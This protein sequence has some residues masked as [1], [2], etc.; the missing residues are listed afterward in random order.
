MARKQLITV[1][2]LD[3]DRLTALSAEISGGRVALRSWLTAVAPEQIPQDKP[4][5]LGPWIEQQLDAAGIARG[6]L[7]LSMGRSDVVLK[8]LG[9]PAGTGGLASDELSGMVRLQM[10]RQLTMPVD[11][12]AIDYIPLG[13]TQ[14]P[15]PDGQVAVMAAAMPGERLDWCRTLAKSVGFKLA[16]VSLRAFGA[17]ALVRAISQ[18][19]ERPVIAVAL[20][21]RTTEFIIVEDGHL[22]FARAADAARPATDTDIDA[23]AERVAVEL[24]RTW[25]SHRMSTPSEQSPLVA[26][27]ADGELARAV[28][29]RCAAAV[30]G[31]CEHV[32][33]PSNVDTL[34][35]VASADRAAITPLVG[36]LHEL[37]MD[38]PAIDFAHPRRAPDRRAA[39]R[40]KSLLAVLAAI[41]LLGTGWAV[42]TIQLGRLESTL[43]RLRKQES[44]LRSD[45]DSFLIEHARVNHMETWMNARVDWLAHLETLNRQLPD[46]RQS[47][48]DEVTGS[49]QAGVTFAPK[50]AYPTGAW[51]CEP[52]AKLVI[53][54]KVANR[55]VAADLRGRLIESNLY[56]AVESQGADVADRYNLELVTHLPEPPSSSRPAMAPPLTPDAAAA[57]DDPRVHVTPA[58]PPVA[59]PAAKPAT[60]PQPKGT[61]KAQPTKPGAAK[62]PAA[63]PAAKPQNGGTP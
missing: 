57:P 37:A 53:G 24:R 63:K 39:T 10:A 9:F 28:G 21:F 26:I 47:L 6:H 23:Y 55:D 38:Q 54:G 30:E 8:R 33:W 3:A 35:G 59:E 62:A 29:E 25:T 20:G 7:V 15:G 11:S 4:D 2:D 16:R 45:L 56:T 14:T 40:Q 22:V 58:P 46:P 49:F 1:L 18:R 32:P 51:V 48:M 60:K 5:A 17:A 42:A 36:L 61:G 41:V 27:L 52:S 19:H 50:G 31:V 44:S 34:A 13:D 12:A 43:E